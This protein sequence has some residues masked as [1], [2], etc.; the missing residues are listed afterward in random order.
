MA[1]GHSRLPGLRQRAILRP[2]VVVMIGRLLAIAALAVLAVGCTDTPNSEGTS[3]SGSASSNGATP[4]QEQTVTEPTGEPAPEPTDPESTQTKQ[5]KPS[6]RIANA[7][8]GGSG[9]NN[10]AQ[11]CVEIRWLGNPLPEGTT[12]TLGEPYLGEQKDSIFVLDQSA[13]DDFDGRSCPNV[14]W[15]LDDLEPC[16]IGLRQVAN[17]GPSPVVQIPAFVTCT[18]QEICDDLKRSS[19]GSDISI[20]PADIEIS[21]SGT[22][23]EEP[24]PDETST[25][26]DESST[27]PDET[28][29][30]G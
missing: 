10:G 29:S 9:E 20:F 11:H 8:V 4:T 23:T 19:G 27:S 6:V 16:R 14:V 17:D 24:S 12:V 26:P 5:S 13:C 25:S 22:P 15:Q 18:T 30:G 7:P 2:G 28:P 3:S 1:D 21:P